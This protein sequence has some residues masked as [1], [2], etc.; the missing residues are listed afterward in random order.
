M[1]KQQQYRI[2]CNEKDDF[3]RVERKDR[4]VPC[5]VFVGGKGKAGL[6]ACEEWIAKHEED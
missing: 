6:E 2:V 5:P 4:T 3:F 1:T